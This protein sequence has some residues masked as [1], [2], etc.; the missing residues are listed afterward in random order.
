VSEIVAPG[1]TMADSKSWG[2]KFVRLFVEQE[3][4]EEHASAESD[5]PPVDPTLSDEELIARYAS[6]PA[7][8]AAPSASPAAP[9]GAV[10]AVPAA[11][12]DFQAV[13]AAAGIDELTRDRVAKARELLLSLPAGTPVAV[14]RA[15]VEASLK[16]FGFP[17]ESI[18]AGGQ[19]EIQALAQHVTS[20]QTKLDKL[21]AEGQ[22]RLEELSREITEVRKIMEEAV[23]EQSARQ[24]SCQQEEG[25]IR[26]VLGFFGQ[27][28]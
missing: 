7:A 5:A 6:S 3:G 26:S 18:L 1:R 2:S 16:A 11:L 20:G 9:V 25:A 22:A 10:G 13:Y 24:A 17:T 23:A 15:I 8:A 14:Q 28:A 19:A 21:L 4:N 12:A 27:G